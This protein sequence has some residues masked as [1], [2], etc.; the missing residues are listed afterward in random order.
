MN[1]RVERAELID[2]FGHAASLGD[3]PQIAHDHTFRSGHGGKRLF[4]SFLVARVQEYAV[5]VFDEK[6][7]RQASEAVGGTRDEDARH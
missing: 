7:S 5:S 2:L 6:L 1:H 4:S 3:V